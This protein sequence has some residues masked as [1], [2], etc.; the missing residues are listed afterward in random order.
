MKTFH[1]DGF[2]IH[3]LRKELRKYG[4]TKYSALQLFYK[5]THPKKQSLKEVYLVYTLGKVGSQTIYLTLQ[6]NILDSDIFHV[7]FLSNAWIEKK[8]FPGSS[9]SRAV[10]KAKKIHCAI[11]SKNTVVKIVSMVR[12][13]ISKTISQLFQTPD[14]FG[15]SQAEL[16]EAD[17]ELICELLKNR[18]RSRFFN[19]SQWFDA[20]FLE[21]TNIDVYQIPFNHVERHQ[22]IESGKF[23]VLVLRNEDLKLE[24]TIIKNLQCFANKPISS[25][26][27]GNATVSRR[28]GNLYKQVKS[29]IR[30]GDDFLEE[31]YSSKYCTH[32]YTKDELTSFKEFWSSKRNKS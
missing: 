3:S 22:T 8:D 18:E 15:L 30:F 32:F 10:K 6:E 4:I 25:L 17:A 20:E 23:Q 19:T 13:P 31:V 11:N 16:L 2:M 28:T 24:D 1:R 27:T 9:K 12:D 29:R 26:K 14:S 21:F 5:L 7:H